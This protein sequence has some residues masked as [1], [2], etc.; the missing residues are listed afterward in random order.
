MLGLSATSNGALPLGGVATSVASHRLR[1]S[2]YYFMI[3]LFLQ[4]RA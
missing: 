2:L 1:V 4:L 3:I